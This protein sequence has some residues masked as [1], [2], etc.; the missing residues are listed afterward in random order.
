MADVKKSKGGGSTDGKLIKV[1]A[2]GSPGTTLHTAATGVVVGVYSEVW[3]WA[4]NS[5]TSPRDLT[6][7]WGGTTAPDDEIKITL[8]TAAAGAYMGA[9]PVIP[10]WVLQNA[11]VV[12]GY[13]SVANK[14]VCHV[15]VNELVSA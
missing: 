14:I 15:F 11:T 8:P 1:A 6:I 13:A 9:L 7:Q 10:G 12:R 2:T 4:Y 3:I 5:D